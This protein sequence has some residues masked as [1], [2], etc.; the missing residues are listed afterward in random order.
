VAAQEQLGIV[1]VIEVVYRVYS[2]EGYV[3]DLLEIDEY[4]LLGLGSGSP[5]FYPAKCLL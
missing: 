2:A 1:L 5:I 3:L 4:D